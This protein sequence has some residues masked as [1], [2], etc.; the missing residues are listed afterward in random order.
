MPG[1]DFNQRL[2]KVAPTLIAFAADNQKLNLIIKL[3]YS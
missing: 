2:T 1:I 3:V